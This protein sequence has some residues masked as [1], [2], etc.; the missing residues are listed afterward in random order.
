MMRT[1]DGGTEGGSEEAMVDYV[2]LGAMS[3][4]KGSGRSVSSGSYG[5]MIS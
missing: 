3:I 5:L 2:V 1:E 4:L